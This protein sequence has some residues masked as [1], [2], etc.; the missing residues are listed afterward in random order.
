VKTSEMRVAKQEHPLGMPLT[1]IETKLFPPRLS[2]NQVPRVTLKNK[3]NSRENC[4]LTL[5]SAP[6]GYGK[7]TLLAEWAA[8]HDGEVAWLSLEQ[9]D[10]DPTRFWS[11]I[12]ASLQKIN[13]NM[14]AALHS[15]LRSPQ[16]FSTNVLLAEL[17]DEVSGLQ[18]PLNIVLD[19]YQAIDSKS[20]HEMVFK[21]I[22]WLPDQVDLIISTRSD[23]PFPLGRLR[24]RGELCE[25]RINDIRFDLEETTQFLNLAVEWDLSAEEISYLNRITE[26]WIAGLQLSAFSMRNYS[27]KSKF[28]TSFAGDDR[29]V[30]DYLVQ[31]VLRQQPKQI[32]SFLI[33]TS[34]LK[35]L[36]DQVCHAVTDIADCQKILEYL[37]EN[38]LFLISLDRNRGWYRYHHLFSE[39]LRRRLALEHPKEI[40]SIHQRASQWYENHN[41]IHQAIYHALEMEDYERA[42]ELI[43]GSILSLINRGEFETVKSWIEKIP[44]SI[45]TSHPWLGIAQVWE[46]VF[47][48][49]LDFIQGEINHLSSDL[50]SDT[51]DEEH[52]RGHLFAIKA[53]LSSLSG[54]QVNALEHSQG[55][56]ALLPEDD[57]FARGISSLILG[58]SLRWQGD[59]SAA[60]EAYTIAQKVSK[61]GEDSFVYIYSSSFKGYVMVLMGRLKEGHKE[62]ISAMRSFQPPD[63]DD[64]RES[65]ILGLIHSFLSGV[66]LRWNK[67][68]Q[69]FEHAKKGLEL[70]KRW[71]NRQAIHD[72]YF[73]Y[74]QALIARGDISGA[75]IA[76]KQ[77]KEN[78]EYLPSFQYLDV[79]FQE[80]MMYLKTQDLNYV[81][82]LIQDI[83]IHPDDEIGY[84]QLQTY[85]VL[86]KYLRQRGEIEKFTQLSTRLLHIAENA[87]ARSKEVD[88]YIQQALAFSIKKDDSRALSSLNSALE[89][90]EPERNIYAFM[91][92]GE[93]LI[94]LLKHAASTGMFVDFIGEILQAYYSRVHF[95]EKRLDGGNEDLISPLTARELQVLCLLA[96]GLTSTEVARELV[97][98]V[99]TAR[100]HIKNLYR[101]L[102]VH[103]RIEAVNK[104]KDLSLF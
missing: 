48:G 35:V 99:G 85:Q 43:Q 62:F 1:T 27:N 6:T 9:E 3:L 39:L 61:E 47:S 38:N 90:A 84:I 20:I 83:D 58:L 25:I 101:K 80:G 55:A 18:T 26:G 86:A 65:P 63:N 102:D 40:S 15:T 87:G 11:Y 78:A 77:A 68:D 13:A 2:K 50:L 8:D 67:V 95:E 12:I 57:F 42:A 64:M 52:I 56:L 37:E 17:I 22:N 93:Q 7:S 88:I 73:F 103:K 5:V 97:I 33:Q 66:L 34:L 49:H 89:I 74:I 10:N 60:I 29:F 96:V 51:A 82:K 59:L 46:M 41:F 4:K 21:F 31:E 98:S 32:S 69:S 14:G 81:A 104:A 53:C 30:A 54:D 100:T 28:F 75:K 91:N 45:I 76:I 94:D 71:G 79:F 92:E 36:S 24:S 44:K 70:S 19:D 16:H 72:G 23:P